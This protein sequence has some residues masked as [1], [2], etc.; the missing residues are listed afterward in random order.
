MGNLERGT[1]GQGHYLSSYRQRLEPVCLTLD[2]AIGSKTVHYR[3]AHHPE[4]MQFRTS[5]FTD[6]KDAII[7]FR[8][9]ML[10]S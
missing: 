1:R 6:T 3:I 2:A 9:Q 8:P 10:S 5:F 7:P 4:R